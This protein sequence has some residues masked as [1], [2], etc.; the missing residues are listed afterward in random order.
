MVYLT[1]VESTGIYP[2]FSFK[3]NWQHSSFEMSVLN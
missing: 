3:N 1:Q 2:V